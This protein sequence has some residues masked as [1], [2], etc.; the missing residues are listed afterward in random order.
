[1]TWAIIKRNVAWRVE[2]T[3]SGGV[4]KTFAK[5]T[6]SSRSSTVLSSIRR[7]AATML[8]NA[9][10]LLKFALILFVAVTLLAQVASASASPAALQLRQDD[11]DS[12]ENWPPPDRDCVPDRRRLPKIIQPNRRTVWGVGDWQRVRWYVPSPASAFRVFIHGMGR[13]QPRDSD[14]DEPGRWDRRPRCKPRLILYKR[15]GFRPCE[16]SRPFAVRGTS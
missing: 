15:R 11:D 5:S 2:G 10:V 3:S 9:A 6:N 14:R 7:T 1:M 8:T 16:L 4:Q 12:A 13:Q